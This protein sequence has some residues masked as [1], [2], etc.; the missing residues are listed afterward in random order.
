MG[1][2]F[3]QAAHPT[4]A[5]FKDADKKS[6]YGSIPWGINPKLLN[7]LINQ[8]TPILCHVYYKR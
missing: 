6:G 1:A 7:V 3:F 2:K 8:C 4:D 5:L